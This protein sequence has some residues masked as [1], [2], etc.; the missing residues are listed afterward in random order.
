MTVHCSFTTCML[1]FVTIA[2]FCHGQSS[3]QPD[4]N[5]ALK[6]AKV[7]D[8]SVDVEPNVDSAR[9][10]LDRLLDGKLPKDGW[11][12]AW[13]AWYQKDPVITFDLGE[14]KKIGAVRVYFQAWVR[15]DELRS[16]EVCVSMD[17]AKFHL[18]NEY[19]HIVTSTEKGTWV[20][21]D[22]RSVRARYFQLKPHFQGWGHQ[23]GEVEF[24]ELS[25]K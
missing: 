3:P 19:G 9:Y 20:E 10:G 18:F 4:P 15:D 2:G 7:L 24:W 1:I 25:E 22:L 13:T 6:I 14:N 8:V 11:R 21:M 5:R 12:S 23:W 17:G 16:I